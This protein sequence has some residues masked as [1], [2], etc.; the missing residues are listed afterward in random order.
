[1][2]I[3]SKI[4]YLEINGKQVEEVNYADDGDKE[5]K[6]DGFKAAYNLREGMDYLFFTKA[7]S[8]M[9]NGQIP[10]HKKSS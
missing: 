8:S 1:M 5:R 10:N 4:L 2:Q 7:S 3:K 6:K 9:N